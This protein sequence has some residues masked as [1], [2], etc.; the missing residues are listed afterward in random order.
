MFACGLRPACGLPAACLRPQI[1]IRRLGL[2]PSGPAL[3]HSLDATYRR[4]VEADAAFFKGMARYNA[5]HFAEKKKDMNPAVWEDLS[6]PLHQLKGPATP[7]P[8]FAQAGA[9][10]AAR[11]AAGLAGPEGGRSPPP[12]KDVCVFSLLPTYVGLY[13]VFFSFFVPLLLP[14][15]LCVWLILK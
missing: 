4:A 12:D 11:A 13:K 8:K 1:L 10:A 6:Y 3:V 7:V 2:T 5:S 14:A 15:T 9:A